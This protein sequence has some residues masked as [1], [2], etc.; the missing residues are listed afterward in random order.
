MGDDGA[1]NWLSCLGWGCLAAVVLAALGIGGCVFM[2]YRGSA[3]ART[4]AADYLE[5]V[6]DGRWEEAYAALGPAFTDEHELGEFVAFEQE[7][8]HELGPCDPARLRGT[9]INRETGRSMATLKYHLSC[10][11]SDSDV[12]LTLEQVDDR[13]LIQGIRYRDP[14]ALPVPTCTECGGV[15][16]PGARFCPYCGHETDAEPGAEPEPPASPAV[17]TQAG[18]EA[19]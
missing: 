2:V 7:V 19:G 12:V 10:D 4:T 11:N 14:G 9:S 16:P 3:D 17:T 6:A 8:R 13:W 18:E 5:K 1:R 15:L